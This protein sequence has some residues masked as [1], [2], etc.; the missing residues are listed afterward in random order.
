MANKVFGKGAPASPDMEFQERSGA[1]SVCRVVEDAELDAF[2]EHHTNPS[3]APFLQPFSQPGRP[4]K[5]TV[6]TKGALDTLHFIDDT[7]ASTPSKPDEISIE[8]KVMSM[9]FKDIMVSMGEVPSPYLGVEC[10]GII[11]AVG[12]N[13]TDFKVGDRALRELR[14]SLLH[15]HLP[16]EHEC[17]EGPR[18]YEPRSRSHRPRRLRHGLLWSLRQCPAPERRVRPDPRSRRWWGQ[19]AIM[20]SQMIGAEIYATVGSQAKKT[21]PIETYGIAE[22]R[23]FFSRDTTFAEASAGQPDGRG[24]DARPGT[25]GWRRAPRA[26]WECLAHFGRFVEIGKRDILSATPA[27]RWP[28]LRTTPPSSVD[29]HRSRGTSARWS[30]SASS[31]TFSSFSASG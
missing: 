16:Q 3:T 21:F 27:S 29:L 25:P 7:N 26:T 6:G 5:L 13:V 14:G 1:L 24:V 18:Q 15:I 9:N 22:D 31:T 10:A 28:P 17:G 12:S 2:V 11:N 4:L 30:T 23:I 19:A 8:V 20:L